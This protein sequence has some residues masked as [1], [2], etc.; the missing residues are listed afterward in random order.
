MH[1]PATGNV[2]LV[3]EDSGPQEDAAWWAAAWVNAMSLLRVLQYVKY[4]A[5]DADYSVLHFSPAWLNQVRRY[6]IPMW[7]RPRTDPQVAPYTLTQ[8]EEQTVARYLSAV[9][10]YAALLADFS[11]TLRQAIATAGDYYEGHHRRLS[12]NDKLVDLSV[13][14]EALFSPSEKTELRFRISHSGALP[15]GSDPN[16]RKAIAALLKKAYD[17]RSD[18]VHGGKSPFT[19]GKF[20]EEHLARLGDLV[21][22]AIIRFAVLYARGETQ[23]DTSLAS[24]EE[25]MYDPATLE[26]LRSS[27]D[28]DVFLDEQQL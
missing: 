19:S 18:L 6:G 26:K 17:A 16:D 2:F 14:L 21:R 25:S 5:I 15:L 22:Q 28:V 8:R 12:P 23:R 13:A 9:T 11:T 10:R 4:A 24:I 20:S 1:Y 7:G 3:C 27:T